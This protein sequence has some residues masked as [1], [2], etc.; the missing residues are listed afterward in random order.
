M[1]HRQ[2]DGVHVFQVFGGG[3]RHAAVLP[4][5]FGDGQRIMRQNRHAEILKL[6][7]DVHDARIAQIGDVFLKRQP[8]DRDAGFLT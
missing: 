6:A 1:G 2:N 5:L 3:K 7:D 4:R 8:H